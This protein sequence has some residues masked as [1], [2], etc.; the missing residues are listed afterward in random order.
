MVRERV[1]PVR[2]LQDLVARVHAVHDHGVNELFVIDL[3]R[4]QSQCHDGW[5]LKLSPVALTHRAV[6]VRIDH[7]K[8]TF[9]KR[10]LV[11]VNELEELVV[12]DTTAFARAPSQRN[13]VR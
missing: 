6:A 4:G 8:Q 13:A 1:P 3:N 9:G 7:P 5:I 12:V 10:C 2:T 11:L